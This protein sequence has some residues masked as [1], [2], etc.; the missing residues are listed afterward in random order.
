MQEKYEQ[1]VRIMAENMDMSYDQVLQRA[2]ALYQL[3][4][5]RAA[6]GWA[7]AFIDPHTYE[8]HPDTY[9][10]PSTNSELN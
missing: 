5:R 9:P 2:V 3:A 1:A 6:E 10:R 7:V 8:L 4:A